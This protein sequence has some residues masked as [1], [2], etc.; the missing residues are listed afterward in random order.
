MNCSRCGTVETYSPRAIY[1]YKCNITARR[2]SCRRYWH[3]HKPEPKNR[4]NHPMTCAVCGL[5]FNR[6]STR[7][8]L[9]AS[10]GIDAHRRKSLE[11]YHAHKTL[12]APKSIE[13]PSPSMKRSSVIIAECKAI[14]AACEGV[15]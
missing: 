8:K 11:Y 5:V 7:Q 9:C 6:N 14:M 12:Q 13:K 3:N 4:V 15:Q 10:C 1:C 2:E